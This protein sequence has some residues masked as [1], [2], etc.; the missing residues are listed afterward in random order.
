M[1]REIRLKA[2]FGLKAILRNDARKPR[3]RDDDQ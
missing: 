2:S 1:A 3:F